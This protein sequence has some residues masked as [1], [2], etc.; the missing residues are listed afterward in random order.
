MLD[1]GIRGDG[2]KRHRPNGP[3]GYPRFDPPPERPLMFTTPRREERTKPLKSGAADGL[4]RPHHN[5]RRS[6]SLLTAERV[7]TGKSEA[8][9]GFDPEEAPR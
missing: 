3:Q 9:P 8:D 7:C 1:N 2:R 5:G 6:G 4:G